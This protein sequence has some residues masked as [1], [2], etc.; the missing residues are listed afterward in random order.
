[1]TKYGRLILIALVALLTMA[2][3]TWGLYAIRDILQG[4]GYTVSPG[5]FLIAF[6]AISGGVFG[7]AAQM[8]RQEIR[9]LEKVFPMKEPPA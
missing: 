1:M 3:A 4:S 7:F 5:L 6:F 8:V 2:V 9:R